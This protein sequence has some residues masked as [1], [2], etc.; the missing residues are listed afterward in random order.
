[1]RIGKP[2]IVAGAV[3]TQPKRIRVVDRI[4]IRIPVEIEPSGDPDEILLGE[5]PNGAR[6]VVPLKDAEIPDFGDGPILGDCHDRERVALPVPG[7]CLLR[8]RSI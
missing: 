7:H 2:W 5:L 8:S 6:I 4:P 1:M 3:G